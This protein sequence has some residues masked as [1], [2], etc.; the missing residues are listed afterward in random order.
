MPPYAI[1]FTDDCSYL[2]DF[3]EDESNRPS[4]LPPFRCPTCRGRVIFYCPLC[5]WPILEVPEKEW[6]HCAHCSA[7]LRQEVTPVTTRLISGYTL[8]RESQTAKDDSRADQEAGNVFGGN[9]G[10]RL[11]VPGQNY[12]NR[13]HSYEHRVYSITRSGPIKK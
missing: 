6:P 1:C 7:R 10:K 11:R 9:S 8:S 3:R 2:F 5:R 12:E 13:S 4:R